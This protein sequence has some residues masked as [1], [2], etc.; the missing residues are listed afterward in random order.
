MKSEQVRLL[1]LIFVTSTAAVGLVFLTAVLSISI[2]FFL[3]SFFNGIIQTIAFVAEVIVAVVAA[4]TSGATV[5]LSIIAAAG[6]AAAT[7]PAS[8]IQG[9]ICVSAAVS[10]SSIVA[11][12]AAVIYLATFKMDAE[13][14]FAV[15]S[16]AAMSVA[17]AAAWSVGVMS[18]IEK[19][20]HQIGL[21]MTSILDTVRHNN[22]RIL[23][24]LLKLHIG[25][26]QRDL[27]I[28]LLHSV[29][30]GYPEC[31][32]VLLE[33]GA[34]P[35][36][37]DSYDNTPLILACETG[38]HQTVKMLLDAGASV[39]LHGG[40]RG[41]ALHK[42][43]NWGYD[44]CIRLLLANLADP[45]AQDG[46][47]R[48]PLM[49]AVMHAP[50]AVDIIQLLVEAGCE[51]NMAGTELKT[52]IHY[53]A[54]R[55]LELDILLSAGA[56]PNALDSGRHTP[57]HLAAMQGHSQVVNILIQVGCDV[58]AVNYQ[59]RTPLHLSA[60]K[61]NIECLQVLLD[62]GAKTYV[63]DSSGNLP[64]WYTAY[65]GHYDATVF[66]IRS[67]CRMQCHPKEGERD[68]ETT[69]E[70]HL[71]NPL[72]AALDKRRMD[73]AR[74]LLLSGCNSHP[75]SDWLF[76]LPQTNWS[77]ENSRHI[78]WMTNFIQNPKELSHLCRLVVRNVIGT[79]IMKSC[80]KLPL[81]KKLQE[82]LLM[83]ELLTMTIN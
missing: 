25:I 59:H 48:T 32:K 75:L 22:Y 14:A 28:A 64:I 21:R 20:T 76:T 69:S 47:W 18:L 12:S 74:V 27:D 37:R 31:T 5:T 39:E 23:K 42:A 7:F 26:K 78:E 1:I 38:S 6:A 81:P 67:N 29:K 55:G 15:I 56:D 83:N 52:A 13:I 54:L 68:E 53:A 45:N 44:E 80:V 36:A 72:V 66:F 77:E 19:E 11:S 35:D 24:L 82:Y 33:S 8:S 61:G 65:Y 58:C 43:S 40:G 17:F 63:I 34:F 73:I 3:K 79:R 41:T 46:L 4:I 9:R 50:H 49:L 70:Q 71:S 2:V 62:D 51:V 57:L 60:M 30:A 10:S 16:A